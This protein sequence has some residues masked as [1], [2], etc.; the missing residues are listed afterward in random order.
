MPDGKRKWL[1]AHEETVNLMASPEVR[2]LDREWYKYPGFECYEAG[3]KRIQRET[4]HLMESLGYQHDYSRNGYR[5]VKPNDDRIAL[6]AHEG[7]GAAF[8]SCLLD[9]PYP[10]YANR[11]RM[12]HSGM[13][14]IEFPNDEIVIPRVLQESN[15]SHLFA[16]GIP[17]NYQNR[18]YF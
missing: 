15:D 17:T 4:D 11:F 13:T 7:F 6:F 3:M 2:M 10:L 8:L 18:I 16:A 9:I 12:S 1:W 5:P 14:V